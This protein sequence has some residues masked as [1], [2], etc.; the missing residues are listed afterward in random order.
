[1]KKVVMC[2]LAT[3]MMTT[4]VAAKENL[5]ID[6]IVED[7]TLEYNLNKSTKNSAEYL[8]NNI[9]INHNNN[10]RVIGCNTPNTAYYL[11]NTD[12]N[13]Y[14]GDTAN[15][16]QNWYFFNTNPTD[17]INVFLQDTS[18]GDYDIYLYRYNTDGTLSLVSYSENTGLDE[19]LSYVGEKTNTGYYW[20]LINPYVAASPSETYTFRVETSNNYDQYEP[21]NNIAD[22]DTGEAQFTI[23]NSSQVGYTGAIKGT[24]DSVH[25]V[26]WYKLNIGSNI[27]VTLK[28]EA[29]STSKIEV[30]RK[31][32]GG[33]TSIYSQATGGQTLDLPVFNDNI[34]YFLKVTGDKGTSYDI[35]FSRK[36]VGGVTISDIK[37]VGDMNP[38]S[39][40]GKEYKLRAEHEMYLSGKVVDMGGNPVN[41][42]SLK[43]SFHNPDTYQNST[44]PFDIEVHIN[45]DGTFNQTIHLPHA[46]GVHTWSGYTT[47]YYDIAKYKIQLDY[48]DGDTTYYTEEGDMYHYAYALYSN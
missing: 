33:T 22:I 29:E 2:F 40:D 5:D 44:N 16:L 14:L 43:F 42:A 6:N 32:L 17:K 30:H 41:T 45:S 27:P 7:T 48:G 26:D 1:M 15:G 46:R 24:T 38:C 35:N 21:N 39:Y 4:P 10:E 13:T 3:V 8:I 20:L 18:R 37:L 25:D 19:N 12:L 47:H 11:D 23:N 9:D 36:I 28:F 34:T 31:L